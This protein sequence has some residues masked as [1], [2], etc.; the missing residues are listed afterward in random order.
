MPSPAIRRR[1]PGQ[2]CIGDGQHADQHQHTAVLNTLPASAFLGELDRNRTS[3]YSFGGTVQA[4]STQ[5]FLGH[6]N[7]F[8][9]GM[10]L[11]RGLTNFTA[12]SEL[13]TIDQNLFVHRHRHL[14]RPAGRRHRAG[15]PAAPTPIHRASTRPT[16][17][18]SPTSSRSPPARGSTSPRSTCRT[19]PAPIRCST[20]R[21]TTS[22]STR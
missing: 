11:D 2:L 15:Q 9:M 5:Q 22:A 17:S 6:D 12:T 4:T 3:T 7:H 18:T 13:G 20:A 16:R 8:V 21:T 14:H 1:L 19:R 10:S